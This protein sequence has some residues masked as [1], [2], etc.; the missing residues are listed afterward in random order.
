MTQF[1]RLSSE[2]LIDLIQ[3]GLMFGPGT[4]MPGPEM[5]EV[6]SQ[7]L[8]AYGEPDFATVMMSETAVPLEYRGVDGFREALTDWI[9]PYESFRLEIEDVIVKD[10]KLVFPARQVAKT[11]HGGVELT[12]ESASVWWVRDGKVAQVV[13]YLQQ[14]AALKAAGIDPD[15]TS[16]K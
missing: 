16:G 4:A 1:E 6:V 2:E 12:T 5:I 14:E 7:L 11:K 9:S 10:D 3:R 15:R 8:E 13:F